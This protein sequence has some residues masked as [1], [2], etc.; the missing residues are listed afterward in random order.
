MKAP[1]SEGWVELA[2]ELSEDISSASTYPKTSFQT[3]FKGLHQ[4]A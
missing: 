2:G 1:V 4:N 3:T